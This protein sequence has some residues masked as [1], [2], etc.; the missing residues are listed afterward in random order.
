[1][2]PQSVRNSRTGTVH[3]PHGGNILGGS[4]VVAERELSGIVQVK[5]EV[6]GQDGEWGSQSETAPAV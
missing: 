4:N 5:L 6:P 1:L 3:L 2:P